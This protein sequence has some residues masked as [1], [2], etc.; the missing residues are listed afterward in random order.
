MSGRKARKAFRRLVEDWD[1]KEGRVIS[2]GKA[3]KTFLVN[4]QGTLY[5]VYKMEDG[6][7]HV[8]LGM[9]G[10]EVKPIRRETRRWKA[11]MR[12]AQSEVNLHEVE[13]IMTT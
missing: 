7:C 10:F 11:V 13:F 5:T 1:R 12:K 8:A 2:L 3:D 9:A 6:T 4:H